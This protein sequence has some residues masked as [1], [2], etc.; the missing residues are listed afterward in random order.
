VETG[1]RRQWSE[2]EKLRIVEKSGVGRRQVSATARRHGISRTLLLSWR[3]ARDE[4][5]L[6]ARV[7]NPE[8]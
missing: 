8:R 2:A 1:R 5:R 4:G 6:G 7:M 3:R